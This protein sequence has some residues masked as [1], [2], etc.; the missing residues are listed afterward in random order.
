MLIFIS[1]HIFLRS[2]SRAFITF[3]KWFLIQKSLR[4]ANLE[5]ERKLKK[6]N[7]RKTFQSQRWEDGRSVSAQAS[8]S[9]EL[10]FDLGSIWIWDYCILWASWC[11]SVK[12]IE[13]VAPRSQEYYEDETGS[14]QHLELSKCSLNEESLEKWENV[15]KKLYNRTQG[16]KKFQERG[17]Q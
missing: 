3:S 12:Q 14:V 15:R 5:Q 13:M 8:E 7:F 1:I 17:K 11:S 6:R 16:K 9:E 10:E 4:D 2:K